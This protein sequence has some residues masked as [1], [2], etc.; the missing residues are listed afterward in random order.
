MPGPLEIVKHLPRTN[1]GECGQPSCLAFAVALSAGKVRPEACPYFPG[2][3]ARGLSGKVRPE[4][5]DQTLAILREVKAAV[6]K[7]DLKARAE[8][9]GGRF[10]GGRL[11]LAYLDG[12]V[13]LDAEKAERLDGESL[14]P[15]DQILLYNYVRFGRG[16]PLSGKFV[17]LEA[18]PHSVSKVATLR[19]Y[20]EEPLARALETQ[21]ERLREALSRFRIRKLE[22]RADLAVEV[23]VLPRVPLRIHFWRGEAEEGL[24]GE[25]KILYDQQA[26]EYLDLESLV[27]CAERLVERWLEMAGLSDAF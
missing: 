17:G 18:F 26:P 24:P 14:D 4:V 23:W 20:A 8:A 9:F 22:E 25:V 12:E 16:T 15:R 13:A 21:E 7:I 27:F 19:R 1:C 2:D 5:A 6:Q 10:E 11:L 3:L